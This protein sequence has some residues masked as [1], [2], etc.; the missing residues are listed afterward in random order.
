MNKTIT[1]DIVDDHKMVIGGL[2]DM[3]ESLP[4]IAVGNTYMHGSSLLKGLQ[5]TRPDILMLDI[6]MPDVRGD[7]LAA[8]ISRAYPEMKIIAITG[9]NTTDY[10]RLMLDAGVSG[11]LLK[12]TDEHKLLLAIETVYKGGQYIEP[13]LR[14]K[15][16]NEMYGPST[17][18]TLHV[19]PA[20]TRREKDILRFILEEMTSQEI[21]AKLG[22]SL[23]TIENHRVSLMQKLD[24]KNMAG[25]VKRAFQLG[26]A[27]Q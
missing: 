1:V 24:A 14:D 7:E 12:N 23:R 15:L 18:T 4:G 11:Y 17:F 2:R 19:K 26:L 25:I 8:L 3:L 10:T 20:L 5:K 9:Y 22:L 27:G 16:N 21:A 13:S 6:E